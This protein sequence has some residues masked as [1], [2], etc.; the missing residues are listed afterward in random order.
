LLRFA[1]SPYLPLCRFLMGSSQEEE[2][3]SVGLS[4]VFLEGNEDL[5]AVRETGA[6]LEALANRGLITLDYDL[7]LSNYDYAQYRSSPPFRLFRET[8]AQGAQQP[9]FL[10]DTAILEKGSMALTDLGQAVLEQVTELL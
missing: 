9:G 2:L 1:E 7:A 8:V 10:F 6:V 5:P 3:E 4:P